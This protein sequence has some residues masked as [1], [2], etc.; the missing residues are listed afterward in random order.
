MVHLRNIFKLI[1]LMAA[2]AHC[3]AANVDQD[4][5]S[6]TVFKDCED[7]PEM[8]VI[9]PGSFQMGARLNDKT[10]PKSFDMPRRQITIA[11]PFAI[12]RF[13]VTHNQYRACVAAGACDEYWNIGIDPE[14]AMPLPNFAGRPKIDFATFPVIK[15]SPAMAMQYAAW[16]SDITGHDYHLPSEAEW[17]YAARGG[18]TTRFWWG[19]DIGENRANC[20]ACKPLKDAGKPFFQ[21][22]YV[23]PVGQYPPNPFGLYDVTG[24]V[25][26]YTRD[27]WSKSLAN[28]PENGGADQS[29]DCSY[30]VTRGG[31]AWNK[32]L[33]DVLLSGRS[34]TGFTRQ[35][36]DYRGFRI[37]RKLKVTGN[38]R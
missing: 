6:G 16:L 23:G 8:V 30:R 7:C 13:E 27:C 21:V 5:K 4:S 37:S 36:G 31:N 18:T 19:D 32:R 25:S 11:K 29:S 2:L 34:G 1:F 12:G 10:Y 24:N 14:K 3:A 17:E 22:G 35:T 33:R 26:E 38:V 28:V 15:V 20:K 9:P